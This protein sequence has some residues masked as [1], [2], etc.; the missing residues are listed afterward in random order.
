[1]GEVGCDLTN[2]FL[3]LGTAGYPPSGGTSIIDINALRVVRIFRVFRLFGKFASMR[4]IIDALVRSIF[5]VCSA[6]VMFWIILSIY[7]I[8]GKLCPALRIL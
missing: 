4:Q 7:A 1:M 3:R 6:L 5:P 8:I 2:L